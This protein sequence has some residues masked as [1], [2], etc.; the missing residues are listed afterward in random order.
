[1]SPHRNWFY[2]Y[3]EKPGGNV[4]M[5]NNESCKTMGIGSIKIKMHDNVI[6][7]LTNVKHVPGLKRNL[8]SVGDLDSK[9]FKCKVEGG[10][11]QI[12]S[13]T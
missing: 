7:T 1:M 11:M 10:V 2:H 4:L 13:S 12:K 3:V 5:G 9:G 8:I 6:R